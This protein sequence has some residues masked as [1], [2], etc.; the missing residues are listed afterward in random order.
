MDAFYASVEQRDDPA[1]RGRPV[2]VGG[3]GGRG[4]VAAASYEVRKFGVHS[5]M[6]MRE[7]LRRCPDAIC[8]PPRIV[9]LRRGIEADLRRV[10]RIHAAG[11]G[12]VAGRGLPRRDREHRRVRARPSTSRGKSSGGSASARSSPRPSASRRTS[13]WRR[14][15]P[16]CASPTGSWS[17]SRTKSRRCSTRCRSAGCSAS[18]RR[19]RPRSRR[20]ASTRSASCGARARPALRPIFG[21]YAERVQRARRRHRRP[22]GDARTSTR[23]RSAP[24]RPSRPTSPITPGSRPRSCGWRTGPA[25]RLRA[26]ELAAGCVTV[27]IRRGDFTTY[28]RQRHFEPPTQETRVVTAIALE[29]LRAWLADQPRAALR[30]LGVGVSELKPAVQMDLFTARGDGAQPAARRRRGPDP[31]EVR[32]GGAQAREFAPNRA[33]HS[34]DKGPPRA[35]HARS[36]AG[37]IGDPTHGPLPKLTP[38]VHE[39]FRAPGK[40]VRDHARPALPVPERA[41]RG[42]ARAPAL[43]HQRGRRLHPA[44]RRGRH[45]Q[46][47]GHPQP[48]RAA[49]RSCRRRA[50]PESRASRR[51]SSCS[52][53]ARSCT[54]PV[55]ESGRGST[56]TLMDLLG[57]HLLDTHAR[58][59]RVVLIVDEA[60]NLST[61]DA[62]AGAPAHQPRDRDHEAAADHPDRPAGAARPARPP[63]LRQ[64]AQRIT[65]RYHLDPLSR[66]RIGGLREAPHARR[67]RDRPRSS[68]RR[69]LREIHR[70]S[71]GV[72]RVINVI[73]DRALLGAFT[74]EEHRVGAALVRQAASEVYGRPIPAPW[75]KWATAGSRRRGRGARGRRARGPVVGEREAP[76]PVATRGRR[77]PPSPRSG[78]RAG[79]R[80][81]HDAG[82]GTAP[83]AA[84]RSST[85]CSRA[86]PTTPRPRPRSRSCSRSGA[87]PTTPSQRPRLRAG[88][89]P[90]PRVP[91]PE[92][93]VGA[94]AHAQSPGDPD[95][96]RRRRPHPPGRADGA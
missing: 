44:H 15:P 35:S 49:A 30:L 29:L 34:R 78:R 59:R 71:N 96:D 42:G 12:P 45:R 80:R 70:L 14:S 38:H 16:T 36:R 22:A 63:E 47:H 56:K 91:V 87:R 32:Q 57:R 68:R 54:S 79:D 8:V 66:R 74:R 55:P 58:G 94:A 51:P 85:T 33:S 21:R 3:T 93:L 28:T 46:D 18:A 37:I 7:A 31:R 64:L 61:R 67:G 65:G 1:L 20:S 82:R 48:A 72:P 17:C 95:A 62:R 40:A 86:T 90:G 83:R 27:K 9:A 53:S 11:A 19:P 4:V 26:N 76:A 50:D 39:L 41:A 2:I 89:R 60:Q 25:A 5:A 6:P 10:P 52:R 24:R 88:G 81:G 43:R 75:L 92:G 73:C 23:S 13:W 69:A 84:P 77:R